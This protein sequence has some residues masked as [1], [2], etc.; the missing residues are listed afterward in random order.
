MHKMYK[1]IEKNMRIL[2]KNHA[3]FGFVFKNEANFRRGRSVREN[4]LVSI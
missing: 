1:N 3:N 2:T 4:E